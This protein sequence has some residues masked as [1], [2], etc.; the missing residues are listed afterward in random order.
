MKFEE[1]LSR[2]KALNRRGFVKSHRK[3]PTGIGKTLEDLLEIEENNIS[4]PDFSTYELKSSRRDVKSMVTLFTKTPL[5]KGANLA[6]LDTFGY[7][8][9]QGDSRTAQTTLSAAGTATELELVP[10]GEKEIHVTIDAVK[11]NSVGL[12]LGLRNGLLTII[13]DKNVEAYY[14]RETLKLAFEKKYKK[15]I[16]VIADH[17]RLG[18]HEFFHYNEAYRL[19]GFGFQTFSRLIADGLLKIDL[20]IGHYPDRRL[21]D[22]G[23]A[24]RIDPKHLPKCFEQVERI[25]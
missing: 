9:N 15:M 20:R 17:K 4:G 2:L 19:D 10:I 25:L 14:D 13:N 3:G 5:P 12:M 23:T 1:F 11:P 7:V 16:F 24:F 22:H 8:K 21:H 18:G 6:L